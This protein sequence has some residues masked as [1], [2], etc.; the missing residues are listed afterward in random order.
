MP[1]IASPD[2]I[3][4]SDRAQF[5]AFVAYA[6]RLV[7][8]LGEHRFASF[9]SLVPLLTQ[10]AGLEN[11]LF[12]SGASPFSLISVLPSIR[13]KT[14]LAP[15]LPPSLGERRALLDDC[16]DMAAPILTGE[17]EAY[18][19]LL[20]ELHRPGARGGDVDAA[21]FR[22]DEREKLAVLAPLVR[23]LSAR[24]A[25]TNGSGPTTFAHIAHYGYTADLQREHAFLKHLTAE[26]FE[27]W[28]A[29]S[30]PTVFELNF[31]D[32]PAGPDEVRGW[33][34]VLNNSTE[35]LIDSHRLRKTKIL[36]AAA[37]AR[38]LGAPI[39]GMAGLVAFF[40]RSGYVLSEGYPDVGFTTGHAYT[41]ANITEIAHA[42]AQRLGLS[43]SEATVA[44]V[45]A[46]GSIGSGCAK[47]MAAAGVPRLVLI[48]IVGRDGLAPL[49]RELAR[50]SPGAAIRLSNRLEEIRSADLTIVATNSPRAIV[51]PDLMRP[52][53]IIIDDSFPKN[54]PEETAEVRDDVIALEG[55]IMRLPA[56]MEIDRARNV[57]NVMDVP[58]TRMISCREIY[59]CLAETLTL[60]AS[61]HRGNYGLGPADPTLAGDIRRRAAAFGFGLAPLQFF[62]QAVMDERFERVAR[63][64]ARAGATQEP[65]DV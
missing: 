26:Q 41:I 54:V 13:D 32:I 65:S 40:G 18:V 17:E 21:R 10:L 15:E 5:G 12:G 8:Q 11:P 2:P 33:I 1:E 9:Y 4:R 28:C 52:G 37:L 27:A 64:R 44:I 58:L 61:H 29:R 57:P 25:G 46:A 47:L 31:R 62:G 45:G 56:T 60:A 50:I 42:A 59:G 38:A 35:Q 55:G 6:A 48:D 19:E 30:F 16:Y 53:A 36:Q 51:P 49:E 7:D 22:A 24:P 39:V 63:V 43:V 14:L 3:A 20:E 34:I 23:R